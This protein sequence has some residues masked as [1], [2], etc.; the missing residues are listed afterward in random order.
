MIYNHFST[1]DFWTQIKSHLVSFGFK[2]LPDGVHFTIGFDPRSSYINLHLSKNGPDPNNKPKI[3][4]VK[5]EKEFLDSIA[6]SISKRLFFKYWKPI[7]VQEL[8]RKYRNN[9]SYISYSKVQD[10]ALG[11]K[12]EYDIKELF[13]RSSEIRKKTRVKISPIIGDEIGKL[14]ENK[15]DLFSLSKLLTKLPKG[16]LSGSDSGTIF[17]P[18]KV[19]NVIRY[20][21]QWFIKDAT[22]DLMELL[23]TLTNNDLARRIVWKTKKAL[24][25]LKRAQ[26]YSDTK[27]FDKP[28]QLVK[29]VRPNL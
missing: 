22:F 25:I 4:I 17:T 29:R 14:Y 13:R 18:D 27:A 12:M 11:K 15:R 6:E 1:E 21:N 20:E 3:T 16:R 10:S 8:K 19:L 2:A 28:I 24:V 7:D 26:Y 5:I 23:V 9:L